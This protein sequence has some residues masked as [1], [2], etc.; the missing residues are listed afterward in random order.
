MSFKNCFQTFSYATIV[1]ATLRLMVAGALSIALA[2][3]LWLLMVTAWRLEGTRWQLSERTGLIIVLLSIPF[4]FIDWK[5]Q[6]G[7]GEPAGRLGVNALAHLIVFLSAVK[8][9][10]A[11]KDRDWVFLYLISFFE[12]LLAAGLSFSPV[13]LLTL[14]LYLLCALSAVIAFE[15]QKARRSIAYSETRLLV[16][17]DSR[18]FRRSSKRRQWRNSEGARLPLVAVAL[19]V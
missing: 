6:Q 11:K 2:V 8:L 15:I 12:V 16:P 9:L 1:V 5:Y 18:V 13:F 7:I 3:L 17:P 4:F 19:L 14:A 10:Q